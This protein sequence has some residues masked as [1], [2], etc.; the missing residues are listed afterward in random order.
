MFRSAAKV[1]QNRVTYFEV[2]IPKI[3]SSK[4]VGRRTFWENPLKI[5]LFHENDKNSFLQ[6]AKIFQ[7]RVFNE[8][9]CHIFL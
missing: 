5:I 7:N 6:I 3:S 1:F 2:K 9:Q 4:K 8:K